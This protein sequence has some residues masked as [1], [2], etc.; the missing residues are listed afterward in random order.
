MKILLL[1]VPLCAYAA[2]SV[3][4]LDDFEASGSSRR[5]VGPVAV[6]P[7]K[8]AHGR[9]SARV[10][11]SSDKAEVSSSKLPADWSGYDR[12]LFDVYHPGERIRTLSV[13]LYDQAGSDAGSAAK[14]DYFEARRKILLQHGWNHVEIRLTGL[15]EASY[16]REISLDR[17]VRLAFLA[18]STPLVLNIDNLRLVKG[19]ESSQTMSTSAPGDI[20]SVIENRWV[21]VRQ[22]GRPED[23]PELAEVRTLRATAERE[24]TL[25]EK[26]IQGARI[27]GIDPIYSERR[28][29]VADLGLHVRPVLPWFN[30][31]VS[32][33]E[34]F[35]YIASICRTERQALED[36]LTGAHRLPETDDTQLPRPLAP[37]LP[38]L[39]G[40]PAVGWF[41]RDDEGEPLNILS[42]HSPSRTL[43]RFFATPL[44]HIESY[45]VG[46]ASRWNLEESPVYEA[47]L[48]DPGAKREGWDG[49]CGH[50]IRDINSMGG[51]RKDN[52]VICLENSSIRKAISEYIRTHVPKLR[53]NPELLYNIMA[54][55]LTYI[56]Y[57]DESRR[58]FH[59]W[60]SAKHGVVAQMNTAWGTAYK[61]LEEVVP[62]PVKNSRPLP[63]TNRALWYDWARFNQDRFT[64]HL[65]WVKSEI[66]KYDPSTPLAAGGSSSMLAGRTGTTGIDEERIVNEV[67]DVIIHEGAGST[68]GMDLQRA[69]ANTPKPLAD[70]EMNVTRVGDLLPH[71]LHGKSVIQ[72]FHWPSQ[73]SAEFHSNT[74][75][76]WAHSWDKPLSEVDELLRVALDARRLRSEIASFATVPAQ[77]AILYS[78]TATLQLP[79][80]ML[81]WRTTP[82]LSELERAYESGKY[83]DTPITFVTERQI[84]DGRAS[85]YNLLIV[86]GARNLPADVV[87]RI[88][89]FARSGGRVL[90]MPESLVADE[91]DRAQPWL[92]QIGITVRSTERPAITGQ[93]QQRQGY[94]QTFEEM[95]S[96]LSAE[97]QPMRS[98][99]GAKLG[100]I[101]ELRTKGVRQ[102]I[103]I[104]GAARRVL[105]FS[106]GAPA[107]AR[108]PLGQGEIYYSASSLEGSDYARLWN[109]LVN[110]SGIKR[111]LQ[112]SMWQVE[113]RLSK[114][115]DRR[116]LYVVNFRNQPVDVPLRLTGVTIEQ[117]HDLRSD[118][119]VAGNIVHL[120][121]GETGIY[122]VTR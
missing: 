95:I 56:C 14:Y 97:G 68:L 104:S 84:R 82:Y 1:F 74:Q 110:Q 29:V 44:Q 96:F 9:N 24:R 4:V 58:M 21:T 41:F 90:I 50:L 13:R 101:T 102:K 30:N 65:L 75:H 73:P 15:Q 62:P 2:S 120:S 71:M 100:D 116:L 87:A 35:R 83:L 66:R 72:I 77:I 23:V 6:D 89:D 122:E 92:S 16:A 52:V 20:V 86:P 53:Q 3:L 121:A 64:D 18:D 32:K 85:R 7:T 47:F 88:W 38:P 11:F 69:L 12:L 45:T 60:L 27:Q 22:V 61:S 37:P 55:E 99:P 112:V 42:I 54:Y 51:S 115:G 25:L 17:V 8:A 49:W 26:T 31:D 118:Q 93:G 36:R 78:Q 28:L 108:T 5:W 10:T 76:S 94:D 70:P 113:A 117:L 33:A 67:D 106:D 63:G 46:G 91:Y 48:N 114:I 57:C 34:M 98:T 40:R 111:E 109:A 81:T 103:E 39:R 80:E 19:E 79:P 107:L 119:P 105:E 59:R 43:E